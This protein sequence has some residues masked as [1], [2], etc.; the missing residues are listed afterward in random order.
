MQLAPGRTLSQRYYIIRQLGQ[1]GFGKT[2]LAEDR[3]VPDHPQCVVKQLTPPGSEPAIL[4]AARRLFAT[5]AKTLYQLGHH[6]Q[7]PSLLAYF[8]ENQEF[9]LV[10][11]YIEG[12]ILAEELRAPNYQ[13]TEEEAIKLIQEILEIV[14]FIQQKNVIHRDINPSNLIRRQIDGKLVLIDFGAVKQLTTQLVRDGKTVATI[15]VGTP[16]Y[17]PSEQAHGH[18]KF[19][20]DVYAVGIIALQAL[21][22]YNPGKL[23]THSETG[24]I[25]WHHLANVSPEFRD[26]LDKMIRYDYRERYSS[27]KEALQAIKTLRHSYVKEQ[28]TTAT[29]A[30]ILHQSRQAQSR[31]IKVLMAL[32]IIGLAAGGVVSIDYWLSLNNATKMYNKGNTLYQLQRYEDALQA[33]DTSLNINPNNANAWQG[34]GDTLQAL[35][36]YQ[37]ALDS[38]DEAIQIQ[39]DSWQAWMGRGKVLEKLGRNLEAINSYEKVIIFKDNSWEAWSNLGELKVKLA[40]YSEAIKDLEKSLKLNPDN[41][42]AWY[43]K[44]WSLQNLKKYE[45]AIK[46]YDETVKVNSSFSQAWYQKGNIY[47]NLEKYNE[48]SENYAKAVQFQPDLYQAWYSQGIA[49]NR[50]NRYEEALK[51]FEK[52]T[53]VQSLS[54]E[55]WYQKAWTLHILKRYA[56]A[57]SAY[58]TAIRLRPRDQQAWYNKANSLYNFGEYEEATAAYKQVIALQKDY[59]PAWKSLGNSLLKLERYQEAINAY[60]QALRYKPDQPEVQASKKQAEQ[61]LE[62]TLKIQPE[63]TQQNGETPQ[64]NTF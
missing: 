59:Y 21:T 9:Y 41:E 13:R 57:V 37:Q 50:L 51:T 56:E 42:E 36:R 34:K 1:G 25:S 40:Q 28:K 47:M 19:N 6:S 60:N 23:P 49:L 22:G 14:V 32:A 3:H 46:S 62:S 52:A 8:E 5:E 44:G 35:K 11:E 45:D 54:F 20:S 16:G 4:L 64:P 15:A 43:Q 53:Q 48:A 26:I 30:A 33:Y 7:I 38:Y 31:I 55:A 39:P 63:D 61:L 12:Q 2:F 24:E 18:P 10:Q 17:F 27:A 58:T 29:Q